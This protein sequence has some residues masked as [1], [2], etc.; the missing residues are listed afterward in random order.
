MEGWVLSY[1][2]ERML[3]AVAALVAATVGCGSAQCVRHSQCAGGEMCMSGVCEFAGRGDGGPW[4]GALPTEDGGPADI[5]VA[6]T[7]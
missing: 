4:D 6:E 1:R 3:L 2:S 5:E 7:E